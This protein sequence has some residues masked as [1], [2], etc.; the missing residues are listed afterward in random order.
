MTPNPDSPRG[1]RPGRSG[2]PGSRGFDW[3]DWFDPRRVG[4]LNLMLV[5]V[6]IGI[7]LRVAGVGE[8]WQFVAAGLA[9]IPLAGL[10]GE[11][12]EHLAHKLGP[13]IGGLMNATFGNAAELI[14]A[15]FALFRGYDEVVKASITG[16]IIGNLLL[17]MGASLLAGGLKWPRLQ[18]N[19]TAA[20]VGST[21]MV[22]AAFGMLIPAIFYSLPE[23]LRVA[24]EEGQDRRL[25]LEHELSVGVCIILMLTY[26]LYLVFSLKTHQN[27][28]NPDAEE[29]SPDESL[30]GHGPGWSMSRAVGTLLVA[31]S[32]VA[33]MSEILIGAVEHTSQAFGLS[34]VFVGVIIV[35]IVGNA[36]E[37]STAILVALKNKMDLSVGIAIG[38]ALQ[39]ALFVAPVLV[40]ASYLREEPM[41]LLFTTLEVVAVLLAVFIARM[42]AEDGESNWLEGAMLLMIYAILAVAFFV[43][44]GGEGGHP[45]GPGSAGEIGAVEAAPGDPGP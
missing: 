35:A 29:G 43:L 6:P 33:I 24:R 17:V 1:P 32:F 18:F 3:R 39:I 21:M 8:T 30:H 4:W 13:G 44:P 22:L 19:R 45:P 20:G 11:S 15:L 34:E 36:A 2:D 41:D 31:T 28:F 5:F 7:A 16:S 25:F 37:H 42:V 27:L 14:I 40:F 38:S 10:M 23:V 12:T 26:V 9:I